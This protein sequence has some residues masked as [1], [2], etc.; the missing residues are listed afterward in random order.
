MPETECW[1]TCDIKVVDSVLT[2][3][4]CSGCLVLLAATATGSLLPLLLAPLGLVGVMG[5]AAISMMTRGQCGGPTR[6]V[7]SSG[8]CCSLVINFSGFGMRF[9]C[10]ASCWLYFCPKYVLIFGK[11]SIT[12][13]F[14]VLSVLRKIG[15]IWS[16]LFYFFFN[17]NKQ[18]SILLSPFWFKQNSPVLSSTILHHHHHSQELCLSFHLIKKKEQYRPP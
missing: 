17:W 10:P 15:K 5:M 4:K 9:R 14:R 16:V 6:C 12:L 8:Q 1:L 3:L 13:T 11:I 7:S 18:S 2:A